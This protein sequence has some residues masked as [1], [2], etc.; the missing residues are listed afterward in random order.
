MKIF[1]CVEVKPCRK[2]RKIIFPKC[3][4]VEVIKVVEVCEPN[5]IYV[6]YC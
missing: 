2:S 1:K 3:E 4:R 5:Y 6:E